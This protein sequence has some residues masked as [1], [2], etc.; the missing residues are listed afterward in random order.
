MSTTQIRT[1][2]EVRESPY[3]RIFDTLQLNFYVDSSLIVKQL[4]D[5]WI[6]TI[7]DPVTRKFNYYSKYISP[8]IKINVLD[9]K[10]KKRYS[11]SLFECYPKAIG[12]IQLDQ[13]GKD[14]MKLNIT[15]I[16]KYIKTEAFAVNETKL[17]STIPFLDNLKI[18]KDYFSDFSGFQNKYKT[19]SSELSDYNLQDTIGQVADTSSLANVINTITKPP[20]LNLPKFGDNLGFDFT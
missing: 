9:R 4:F 11:V 3:E 15:M 18:P 5:A 13:A 7:Q 20:A 6:E 14:V 12:V 10:S 1:F 16:Y 17:K 19:F 8:V 2:G